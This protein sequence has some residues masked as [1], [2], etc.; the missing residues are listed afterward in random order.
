MEALMMTLSSGVVSGVRPYLML[1]TLGLAGRFF[2]LDIVPAVMQRTDVLVIAAILLVVDFAA[3]KIQFLDSIWDTIHTVVRPVAG[4]AIGYLLAGETDTMN[5]VVLAIVGGVAALGTHSAK[6]ATRA[7]VNASPEPVSNIV[8]STTE[9]V[10]AVVMALL[11]VVLPI[12]AGIA[13]ILI[14]VAAIVATFMLI[15]MVQRWRA[16]R[17][18]GAVAPGWGRWVLGQLI[19]VSRAEA[20]EY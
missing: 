5:A 10:A 15:R 18:R 13:A 20:A 14:L 4:A 2:D 3:D 8:V 6:A 11:A 16:K 17:A 12:V 7:A 19:L 9:D 1:F